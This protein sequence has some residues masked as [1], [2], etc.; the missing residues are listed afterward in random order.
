[1][2]NDKVTR[3]RISLEDGKMDDG[4]NVLFDRDGGQYNLRDLNKKNAE[5]LRRAL[6]NLTP[7]RII[8]QF[9]W[10]GITTSWIDITYEF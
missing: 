10:A 8:P 4:L 2:A 6:Y 5:R 1:M 3:L 7:R 9:G